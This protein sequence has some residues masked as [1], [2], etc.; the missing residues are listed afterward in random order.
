MRNL[1]DMRKRGPNLVYR[2]KNKYRH[3]RELGLV[4]YNTSSLVLHNTS[5]LV[6]HNTNSLVLHNTNSLVLQN[7]S[8]LVLHNTSSSVY[9]KYTVFHIHFQ[10]P[11]CIICYELNFTNL[12]LMLRA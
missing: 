10:L 6:L 12:L 7:T 8:S 3:K 11:I 5:S 9:H 4:L 1:T 2:W